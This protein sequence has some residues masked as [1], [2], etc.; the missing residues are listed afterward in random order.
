MKLA[1]ANNMNALH[2][3]L[4]G[5]VGGKK[6]K[7][8]GKT[9]KTTTKMKVKDPKSSSSSKKKKSKG[10]KSDVLA[11]LKNKLGKVVSQKQHEETL[12]ANAMGAGSD[13]INV[14]TT[15]SGDHASASSSV[16]LKTIGS[17]P[18][19]APVVLGDATREVPIAMVEICTGKDCA[20]RGAR[21]IVDALQGELPRGWACK[22]S[23]KCI[24]SCKRG[25]NARLHTAIGS[26]KFSYLDEASARALFVPM[27]LATNELNASFDEDF[28]DASPRVRR[29][30]PAIVL[31][32]EEISKRVETNFETR[33]PQGFMPKLT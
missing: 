9:K 2:D 33:V 20:K 22:G 29:R 27:A 17:C 14:E 3:A 15:T 24:S 25:V 31:E 11:A 30:K 6:G 26:E 1:K 32:A 5:V 16:A 4:A 8:G 18:L 23:G 19:V 28:E 12:R 10:K 21:D 7:G 13:V